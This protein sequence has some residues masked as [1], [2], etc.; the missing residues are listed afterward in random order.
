MTSII[1]RTR[2]VIAAPPEPFLESAR[3]IRILSRLID[4]IPENEFIVNVGSG[5]SD[6]GERVLN[7]DIFDSG[8]TD[9][10][11]SGLNLPFSNES[12][13]LVILQGVLEHVKDAEKTLNECIRIM[14]RGGKFYTEMPFMQPYHESPIDMRRCTLPG[15]IEFCKPLAEV[16][17]GM[18][19]GPAST[20]T[21]IT[22]ELLAGLLSGGNPRLYPKVNSLVGWVVFPF[23][24]LDH[25][26]ERK[27][28]LHRIGSSFYFIGEKVSHSALDAGTTEVLDH[29]GN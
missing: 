20:L 9:V 28:Y 13:S 2:A 29:E 25:W 24:Y 3:T 26:L 19:V 11:A 22:R 18:N 14:K 23:K 6:Y 17:S 4:S 16:E 15:L 7:T 12:A 27:P 5:F 10:I 1:K 21:W 8:T